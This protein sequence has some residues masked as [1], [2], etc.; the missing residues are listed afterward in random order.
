[1]RCKLGR[2]F[3][4]IFCIFFV[5]IP[6]WTH[7]DLTHFWSSSKVIC[8][9][10]WEELRLR[11]SLFRGISC[12]FFHLGWF[13]YVDTLVS[14]PFL[15]SGQKKRVRPKE[16]PPATFRSL[17]FPPPQEP[18]RN[19]TTIGGPAI[20]AASSILTPRGANSLSR[21]KF[22]NGCSSNGWEC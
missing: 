7:W 5:G 14:Y 6:M 8:Q 10:I 3:L 13:A 20:Q 15:L 17:K 21:R 16:K 22:F 9:D 12:L 19:G 18:A 2:L 11:W 1:M 4:Y